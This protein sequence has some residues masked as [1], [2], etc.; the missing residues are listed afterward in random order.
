MPDT[1]VFDTA[2][3]AVHGS[4]PQRAIAAPPAPP[5]PAHHGWIPRWFVTV[6]RAGEKTVSHMAPVVMSPVV[7]QLIEAAL[8]ADGL[9]VE[10]TVFHAAIDLINGGAQRRQDGPQPQFLPAPARDGEA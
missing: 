2:D 6:F 3:A 1:P 9:G 4:G 5:V 8:R 10:A 7:E